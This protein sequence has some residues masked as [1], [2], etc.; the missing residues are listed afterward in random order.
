[1]HA[2]PLAAD[3][4]LGPLKLV[5]QHL[6]IREG[7]QPQY[8]KAARALHRASKQCQAA[9]RGTLR[10][11]RLDRCY[12]SL[13]IAYPDPA[14][15]PEV[16]P[17]DLLAACP[18]ATTWVLQQE[19]LAVFN[20]E[21]VPQLMVAAG[22]LKRLEVT[23][24]NGHNWL[25]WFPTPATD[26]QLRGLGRLLRAA[27]GLEE[28]DCNLR[29]CNPQLV[30]DPDNSNPALPPAPPLRMWS[31]GSVQYSLLGS[32]LAGQQQQQQQQPH[33]LI[34]TLRHVDVCEGPGCPDEV[35]DVTHLGQ[36]TG[37]EQLQ[38][39]CDNLAGLGALSGLTRMTH[40]VV[41]GSV[42]A[43]EVACG[44]TGLRHLWLSGSTAGSPE[45]PRSLSSLQQLTCLSLGQGHVK[46]VPEELGSWLPKLERLEVVGFQPPAV[47]DTLK[48]LTHLYLRSDYQ[49][50][51]SLT[52]PSTLGCLQELTI[53][54]AEYTSIVGLGDMA[55][56]R[57]LNLDYTQ[58]L[59]PDLAVLQPLTRLAALSIRWAGDVD[60]ASFTALGGLQQLTSLRLFDFRRCNLAL[61]PWGLLRPLPMLKVLGIGFDQDADDTSVA[62][63]GPWLARLTALTNLTLRYVTLQDGEELLYLP[64]SLLQL[65]LSNTKQMEHLPAGLQ[66]LVALTSLDVSKSSSLCHLPEWLPQLRCLEAIN[67]RETGVVS[68]QPVLALM[69]SLRCVELQYWAPNAEELRLLAHGDCYRPPPAVD[70]ATVFGEATHLLFGDFSRFHAM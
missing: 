33:R 54:N 7:F 58:A 60:P 53:S 31:P 69:P 1:M 26:E 63:A 21:T 49:G 65:D 9:A 13:A 62:A 39:R 8:N 42:E 43:R 4:V 36:A 24:Y 22:N 14:Q 32:W 11:L 55:A 67:L 45:L 27:T 66:Q 17:W 47:P 15:R 3:T 70:V 5:L 59:G 52:L 19:Q 6:S 16:I 48:R 68:E 41:P 38:L 40:L 50:R 12:N 30:L 23:R 2:T 28:L 25:Y 46:G 56:L 35:A 20:T 18:A 61:V 51:G 64:R 29:M 57:V 10:R 44:L 37:L 34:D